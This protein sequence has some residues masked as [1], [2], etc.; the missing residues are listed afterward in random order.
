MGNILVAY[1]TNAGSTGK[2][3]D[4][5]GKEL[6]QN[7][8]VVDVRRMEEVT[9]LEGY[10]GVVVG[11]PMILGWHRAAIKFV[12]Q[13]QQALS[14]VPVA[15]FM[16]AMSLT[17]QAGDDTGLISVCVDPELAK[18]PKQAKRLSFKE[19]YASIPNYLSPALKAAPAV[20]PVS[21]GFFGGKLE[22]P[23][24]K[25]WQMVFVLLI[26]QTQT[27]DFRNWPFIKEWAGMLSKQLLP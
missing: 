11:A 9:S 1:T 25:L 13:N 18:P 16:N 27:G 2:V 23:R 17:Y 24:L 15:Y 6:S 20:K 3:A 10:T 7:G 5:I 26:I 19:R 8:Q 12:K 14:R 21:V 4:I 22:I